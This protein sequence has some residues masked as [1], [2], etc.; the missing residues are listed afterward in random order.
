M[1]VVPEDITLGVML[2]FSVL[3][4]H[5]SFLTGSIFHWHAPQLDHV[6]TI[7]L[8]FLVKLTAEAES[9]A[10]C[11][12]YAE[13]DIINNPLMTAGQPHGDAAALQLNK[14]VVSLRKQ[15]YKDKNC[16]RVER[17]NL[18]TL[19]FLRDTTVIIR[20]RRVIFLLVCWWTFY[21]SEVGLNSYTLAETQWL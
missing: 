9:N 17:V 11:D 5:L 12:S 4:C 19:Y 1:L 16:F 15:S 20:S 8:L 13:K 7:N 18:S 14:F 21:R 3:L 6:I 10:T 2:F